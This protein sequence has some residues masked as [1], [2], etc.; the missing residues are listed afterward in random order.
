[1]GLWRTS[2]IQTISLSN[3][4]WLLAFMPLCFI[5]PQ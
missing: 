5:C 3:D 1:M 4:P 2:H